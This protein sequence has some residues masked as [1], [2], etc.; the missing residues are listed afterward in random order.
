MSGCEEP[1]KNST[2]VNTTENDSIWASRAMA[3]LAAVFKSPPQLLHA[4][5]G[6]LLD[7]ER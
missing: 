4:I 1:G 7:A 2:Q 3:G 6:D 5:D